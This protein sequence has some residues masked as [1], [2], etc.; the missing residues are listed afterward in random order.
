MGNMRL[1]KRYGIIINTEEAEQKYLEKLGQAP[2]LLS[3]AE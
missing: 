3:D 2:R 1:L